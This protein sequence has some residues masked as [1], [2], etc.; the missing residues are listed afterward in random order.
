MIKLARDCKQ[1]SHMYSKPYVNRPLKNRQNKDLN[2]YKPM[3]FQPLI[4][5][6]SPF[7]L[8]VFLL[9]FSN[10]NKTS[11][12]RTVENL[13]RRRNRR[14]LFLFST[15]CRCPIKRALGFYGS[16]TNC[17]LIKVERIAD[18]APLG[19]FCNSFDLHQTFILSFRPHIIK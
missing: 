12:K 19:A 8:A 6:T 14:R 4:K 17:C 10:F 7:P 13:I 3:N 5:C 9:F 1:F 11:C 18:C 15:V 16:M 2:P